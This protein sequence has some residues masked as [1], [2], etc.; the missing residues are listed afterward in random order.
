MQSV[1]STVPTDWADVNISSQ[2]Y[3][4]WRH[5]I[6]QFFSCSVKRVS[7]LSSQ[8]HPSRQYGSSNLPI[9]KLWNKKKEEIPDV[10]LC[11]LNSYDIYEPFTTIDFLDEDFTKLSYKEY[12]LF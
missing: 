7:Y 1:Y 12:V 5:E 10:Q 8:V 3:F 11:E 4:F 9:L 6:K 2:I